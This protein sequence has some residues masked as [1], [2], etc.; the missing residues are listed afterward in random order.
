MIYLN[1]MVILEIYFRAN[2][3]KEYLL[4]RDGKSLDLGGKNNG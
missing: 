2:I 3:I 4:Y 1:K